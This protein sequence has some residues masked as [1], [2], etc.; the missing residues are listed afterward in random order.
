MSAAGARVAAGAAG[1]FAA[2]AEEDEAERADEEEASVLW[3]TC[4]S[5]SFGF[6]A[7]CQRRWIDGSASVAAGRH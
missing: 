4:F 2:A 7:R 3:L 1:S 5:G 6:V